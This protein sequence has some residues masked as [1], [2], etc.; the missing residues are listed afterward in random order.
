MSD[1]RSGDRRV[2]DHLHTLPAVIIAHGEN[3]EPV[4]TS[5][6]A[7]TRSRLHC[8]FGPWEF[9]I[10]FAAPRA[11]ATAGHRTLPAPAILRLRLVEGRLADPMAPE[12]SAVPMAALATSKQRW[13]APRL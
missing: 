13:S 11:H 12:T 10:G 7:D 3:R 4:V 2:G 5:E 1:P 9:A 6:G 8:W